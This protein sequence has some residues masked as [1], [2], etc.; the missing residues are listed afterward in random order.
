MK[1]REKEGCREERRRDV[2][3][4]EGVMGCIEKREERERLE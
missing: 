1:R 3:K 2:E 4:R